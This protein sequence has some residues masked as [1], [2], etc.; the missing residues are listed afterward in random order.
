MKSLKP[1]D[2]KLGKSAQHADCRVFKVF[3]EH[4]RHPDG[5]EGFFYVNRSPDWVQI[6]AVTED[7]K[8]VLV[9][10]FRFGVRRTS[11]ELPGGVIDAEETPSKAAIRELKEETGYGGGRPKLI[12]KI[13]PNPAISNNAAHIYVLE[14]AKKISETHWDA[15]EEIEVKLFSLD[16]LDGLIK[17]GKIHHAIAIDGI[18]FLQKYLADKKD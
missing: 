17:R 1:Q 7:K 18:Y 3:K 11:W 2:W 6:A 10:Q 16:E 5:R 8:I 13:S 14:G 15:N 12:G 4:F 9:N